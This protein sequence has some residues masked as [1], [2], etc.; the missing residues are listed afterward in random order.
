[1]IWV[2]KFIAGF[3][4]FVIFGAEADGSL[5]EAGW[6][7]GITTFFLGIGLALAL[8]L[9]YRDKE[10]DYKRTAWNAGVTWYLILLLM[11]LVVLVG[12]IGLKLDLWFPLIITYFT[13]LVIPIIVG[14]LLAG[15]KI[16][17]SLDKN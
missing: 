16:K 6:I 13:V 1:M 7:N 12:L 3:F 11:D 4:I 9:V 15:N 8:F 14:Y 5:I 2:I 10:Q 17:S